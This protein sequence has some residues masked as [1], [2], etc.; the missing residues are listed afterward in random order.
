[1]RM[2]IALGLTSLSL[3][4][5]AAP[6]V[7]QQ[8]GG[9]PNFMQLLDTNKDGKISLAEYTAFSIESW[10][11][12]SQ[13]ADKVKVADLQG[14]QAKALAGITPDAKGYVSK[15]A[16]AASIPAKFK[17]ADTNG[18]GFLAGAELAR[19]PGD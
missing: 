17:A 7:A 11:R 12:I 5:L 3:A 15:A 16:F 9:R 1:M 18:D 6:V 13:G 2:I 10:G 19:R 4:G 14:F 8:Q